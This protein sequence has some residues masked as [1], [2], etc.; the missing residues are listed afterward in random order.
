MAV[1]D[2]GHDAAAR[3]F[4]EGDEWTEDGDDV[5]DDPELLELAEASV[6]ALPLKELAALAGTYKYTPLPDFTKIRAQTAVDEDAPADEHAGADEDGDADEGAFVDQEGADSD[7]AAA[8]DQVAEESPEPATIGGEC[9]ACGRQA[10]KGW[11]TCPWC[12]STLPA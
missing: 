9:P 2:P 6:R 7:E 11:K 5:I 3:T 12:G 1:D 8:E 10:Q 4:H